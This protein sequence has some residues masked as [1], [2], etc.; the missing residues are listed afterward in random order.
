[1]AGH[2]RAERFGR[3][4]VLA[5]VTTP[6]AALAPVRGVLGRNV[7][8]T[9]EAGRGLGLRISVRTMAGQASVALHV[10]G[11]RWHVPLRDTMALQAIG[12]GRM[13]EACVEGVR[14]AIARRDAALD[15]R[16]RGREG[17][18]IG[19]IGRCIRTEARPS[20]VLRVHE[21]RFLFVARAAAIGRHAP[22]RRAGELVT[23]SALDP[24]GAHVD[25]MP[26]RRPRS[27]PREGDVNGASRVRAA[28]VRALV[29]AAR[30]ECSDQQREQDD[31]G[32]ELAFGH[33]RSS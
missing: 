21:G 28:L 6:A 7:L 18:A 30:R 3:L 19:A 8:V 24:S 12:R 26:G 4:A 32:R 14:V 13:Q 22:H 27:L 16:L 11:D 17:V 31:D 15:G 20:L 9:A 10:D 29:R 5:L 25:P 23:A 2:A 1:M 33:F